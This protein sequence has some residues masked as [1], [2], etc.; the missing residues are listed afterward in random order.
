MCLVPY[1]LPHGHPLRRVLELA[2]K[3]QQKQIIAVNSYLRTDYKQDT[4]LTSKQPREYC[5]HGNHSLVSRL[6]TL[7]QKFH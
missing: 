3:E 5:W 1:T 7:P 2:V 6:V 4:L